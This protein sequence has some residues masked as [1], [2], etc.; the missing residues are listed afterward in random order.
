MIIHR[1]KRGE[2]LR[3]IAA[4]YEVSEERILENNTAVKSFPTTGREL[5]ILRP[6][7]TYVTAAGDTEISISKRFGVKPWMLAANNP[8]LAERGITPSREI[9]VKYPTPPLGAAATNG[10]FFKGAKLSELKRA[11]PYVTYLTIGAYKLVGDKLVRLFDPSEATRLGR[12]ASKVVLMR[13]YD[14]SEGEIYSDKE[15]SKA[16]S[17]ELIAAALAGE[18]CGITLS[19]HKSARKRAA[20]TANFLME[21]RKGMIGCNLVLFIE[22]DEELPTELCELADGCVFMYEKT[23]APKPPSFKNGERAVLTSFAENTESSKAM[24]YLPSEAYSAG[25]HLPLAKALELSSFAEEINTDEGTLLSSFVNNRSPVVYE[26]LGNTKA[27]LELIAELGFTG[28]AFDVRQVLKEQLMMFSAL[29][30]PVHYQIP[31]SL[32]N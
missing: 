32:P 23:S 21:L 9:A 2:S 16:L 31:F 13:V 11:M 29:F 18:F 5:L 30:A 22:T 15:K 17:A 12:D 27:K 6:T 26:S 14:G 20:E 4:E 19:F 24:L 28:A 8:S 10:Y 3:E 25:D 7:R 1:T